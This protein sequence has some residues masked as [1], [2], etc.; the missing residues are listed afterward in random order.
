MPDYENVTYDNNVSENNLLPNTAQISLDYDTEGID[1]EATAVEATVSDRFVLTSANE[2]IKI[3]KRRG[4]SYASVGDTV[5]FWLEVYTTDLDPARK[6]ENARLI[7]LLPLGLD[8][9]ES[10]DGSYEVVENFE[11]T[12]RTAYIFNFGTKEVQELRNEN[13][14]SINA[15]DEEYFFLY[16]Q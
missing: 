7:D 9:I 6:L 3:N 2:K 11:N 1:I 13:N 10:S 12:G 15:N 14:P 5:G 16:V 8:P 4:I